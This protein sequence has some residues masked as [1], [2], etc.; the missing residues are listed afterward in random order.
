MGA[1][2]QSRMI[3]NSGASR[4]EWVDETQPY[5]NISLTGAVS[6]GVGRLH[7]SPALLSLLLSPTIFWTPSEG[8]SYGVLAG[9]RF[10]SN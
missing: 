3:I 4:S 2:T 1:E 8:T 6:V 5:V 10:G 7:S 9:F